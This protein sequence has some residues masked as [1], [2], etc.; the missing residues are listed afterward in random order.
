MKVWRKF[1]DLLPGNCSTA[2]QVGAICLDPGTGKPL[3][4]RQVSGV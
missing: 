2:I 1:L 3:R 4:T